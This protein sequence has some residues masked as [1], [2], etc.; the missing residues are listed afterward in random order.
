MKEIILIIKKGRKYKIEK[1]R[2]KNLTPIRTDQEG[3]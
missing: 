3:T 1:I 2:E